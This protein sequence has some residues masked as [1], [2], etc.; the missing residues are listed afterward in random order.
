MLGLSKSLPWV[1]CRVV[2]IPLGIASSPLHMRYLVRPMLDY[3][4]GSLSRF[5]EGFDNVSLFGMLQL[6]GYGTVVLC[7]MWS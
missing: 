1:I 6:L 5:L 7:E 2:N 3:A 4:F